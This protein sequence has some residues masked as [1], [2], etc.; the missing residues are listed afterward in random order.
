MMTS[1]FLK[2]DERKK[3]LA[4]IVRVLRP[5][6]WFFLKTFLADEDRHAARLLRKNPA[7]EK[8]AYIHPKLGVYEYVWSEEALREF[9]E[10]YFELVKLEK[11]HK[12]IMYGKAF[13]RR[14]QSVYFRKR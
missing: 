10:P 4:E 9:F 14:T 5:G 3:L 7:E 11:S 6:G 13:K 8:G 2:E 12:H 1:H